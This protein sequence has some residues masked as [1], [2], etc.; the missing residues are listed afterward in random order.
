[1]STL[2]DLMRAIFDTPYRGVAFQ[3][4]CFRRQSIRCYNIEDVSEVLD[5]LRLADDGDDV[6]MRIPSVDFSGFADLIAEIWEY[7]RDA[8][9]GMRVP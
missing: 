4:G 1:M 6:V 3:V 9:R 5:A 8:Y 2:S 7:M